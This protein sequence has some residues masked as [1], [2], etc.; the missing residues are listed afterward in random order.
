MP[1]SQINDA[2]EMLTPSEAQK[3]RM[4]SRIHASM[5]KPAGL[6]FHSRVTGRKLFS[7]LAACLLLLILSATAYAATNDR[8]VS[9]IKDGVHRILFT[10]GGSV[11]IE[12]KDEHHT[13]V[14]IDGIQSEWLV[15]EN[16]RKLFLTVNGKP[17]D[18]TKPLAEHGYYYYD[19]K[20]QSNVLHRVY[21]V[22]N[23]G[24]KKDYAERWYSQF[25]WLPEI[26]M[27]GG[28]RGVSGPLAVAIM[29]AES[30]VKESSGDLNSE[31]QAY[32]KVYWAKYGE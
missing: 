6:T 25:E 16:G 32:L 7:S 4:F 5:D 17:Q 20:D 1:Y 26:G 29:N 22:K 8:I 24:G 13:N 27:G 15:K 19:Y 30:G 11:V 21:I 9:N 31:L 10:G 3:A 18:I 23:A 28:S 2:Y 14:G 12:K